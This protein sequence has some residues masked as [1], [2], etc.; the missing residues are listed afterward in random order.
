MANSESQA[1][2]KRRPARLL[3][4]MPWQLRCSES[5]TLF[6]FPEPR[7]NSFLLTFLLLPSSALF[8]LPFTTFHLRLFY[9][10]EASLALSTF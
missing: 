5:V 9:R 3:V 4:P 7:Q 1:K 2:K 8:L 10:V 6:F